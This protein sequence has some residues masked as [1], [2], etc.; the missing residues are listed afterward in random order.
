[1][2]SSKN[3]QPEFPQLA[4]QSQNIEISSFETLRRSVDNDP[5]SYINKNAN[6]TQDAEG[7][8]LLGRAYLLTGK[9]PEAKK[10][11][12]DAKNK[13]AQASLVNGG[14]LANDIALGLTIVEESAAQTKFQNQISTKNSPTNNPN[15]NVR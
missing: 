9:Y 3:Q 6:I 8:Y 5:N 1:L 11:F 12:V 7:L 15:T 14:V 13:L 10:S 4:Q 2:L